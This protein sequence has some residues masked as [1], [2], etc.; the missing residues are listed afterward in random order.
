ML[1]AGNLA[2][3]EGDRRGA[4]DCYREALYAA[5][6]R[7][8]VIECLEEVATSLNDNGEPKQSVVAL[9]SADRERR[10]A[11]SVVPPYRR[12]RHAQLLEV[13]KHELGQAAFGS[14]W[15][16]GQGL[17][18]A[19]LDEHEDDTIDEHLFVNVLSPSWSLR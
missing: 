15:A 7:R 3:A 10:D 1:R 17:S 5:L 11:G 13:L 4:L 16:E 14:A 2:R 19:K 12:Q 8:E 18:P 6:G 9:G